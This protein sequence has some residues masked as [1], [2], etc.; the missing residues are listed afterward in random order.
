MHPEEAVGESLDLAVHCQNLNLKFGTMNGKVVESV[1]TLHT[2]LDGSNFTHLHRCFFIISPM[3]MGSL[4]LM[5]I[6]WQTRWLGRK[7]FL[8][9]GKTIPWHL[10]LEHRLLQPQLP[11]HRQLEV[12]L[13]AAGR[14]RALRQRAAQQDERAGHASRRDPGNGALRSYRCPQQQEWQQERHLRRAGA[15]PQGRQAGHANE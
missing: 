10:P 15:S 7:L 2:Q 8:Y 12:Q 4:L 14:Q 13:V 6:T 9:K 5:P 3:A 11:R 1:E